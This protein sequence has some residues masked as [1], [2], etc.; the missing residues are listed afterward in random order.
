[1]PGA[2][3][4]NIAGGAATAASST[5]NQG[6]CANETCISERVVDVKFDPS[7]STRWA[8]LPQKPCPA[9][10]SEWIDVDW[11]QV[12][13]ASEGSLPISQVALN[14]YQG[15]KPGFKAPASNL[16]LFV[17]HNDTTTIPVDVQPLTDADDEDL[18]YYYSL[19]PPVKAAKLRF[20]FTDLVED[21][22]FG[23]FVSVDEI[24]VFTSLSSESAPASEVN[25]LSI[26]LIVVLVLFV[27]V[28]IPAGVFLYLRQRQ[29]A[30]RMGTKILGTDGESESR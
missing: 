25:G 20:R 4:V 5:W 16:F 21:P 12:Q 1:M 24:K 26:G 2:D 11:S 13:T 7:G 3:L 28:G 15:N 22:E 23:C 19:M 27:A 6:P 30:R 9:K 17:H 18:F 10:Q 14:Y 29:L 8:S